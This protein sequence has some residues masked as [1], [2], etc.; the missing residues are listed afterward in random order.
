LNN[1]EE[2]NPKIVNK[3]YKKKESEFAVDSNSEILDDL[4]RL[5]PNE[6]ELNLS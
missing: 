1:Q 5:N 3:D 6:E 4:K 2:D